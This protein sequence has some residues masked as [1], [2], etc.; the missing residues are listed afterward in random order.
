MTLLLRCVSPWEYDVKHPLV[1]QGHESVI[2][3]HCIVRDVIA[4]PCPSYD[5]VRTPSMQ[6]TTLVVAVPALSHVV[7]IKTEVWSAIRF[8]TDDNR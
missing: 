7:A 3:Y 5:I 6:Q 2:T 8:V 4:C 1:W